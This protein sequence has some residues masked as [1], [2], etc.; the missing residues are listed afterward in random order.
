MC[1]SIMLNLIYIIIIQNYYFFNLNYDRK[2]VNLHLN[3]VI[4][5]EKKYHFVYLFLT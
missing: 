2:V 3:F 1:I 4:N 5:I